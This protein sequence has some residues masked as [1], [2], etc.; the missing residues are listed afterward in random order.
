MKLRKSGIVGSLWKWFREYLTNRY[1][2]VCI[3]NSK[4]STL[5]VVS[6][7][8]QSQGSILGLFLFLIYIND[9]SSS[10]KH[11]KTFLLNFTD[12]TKCLR[13]ICS[14]HDCILLQSDLDVLSLWSTDWKL[15]L[16]ETKCSKLSISSHTTSNHCDTQTD[17]L[18]NGLSISPCNQQKDLGILISSD[19]SWS[20]HISRITSRAYKILGL[21]RRTFASSNNISTKKI[22]KNFISPWYVLNLPMDPKFGDHSYKKISIQSNTFN[23]VQQK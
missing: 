23:V 3:N 5:P 11:S 12:D 7:V 20:H 1:Q 16:N 21:L 9:L 10:V 14:P 8:P 18:I 6:G 2:H 13:P 17:H 22:K 4:S 15:K 19:L